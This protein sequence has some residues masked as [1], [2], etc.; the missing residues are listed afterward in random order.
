MLNRILLFIPT[1]NCEKQIGRVLQKINSAVQ[2]HI[3]EIVLI[4]N[5]STDNTIEA[6][7]GAALELGLS[8]VLL[9]NHENYN[10]GGSI[11][12]AFLYAIENNYDYIIS[13]HG[14]DQADI[15]DFLPILESEHYQNFDLT[16]GARFHKN[17]KL[18]GYSLVRRIGNQV[19]NQ[20]CAVINR[21]KIDDL[22]AGLNC[23]KVNFLQ[24][25]FFLKFPNN[26]TF[27][28][29]LLLYALN[30]KA[31]IIYIPISW[32]QEDQISNAKVLKQTFIILRLFAKYF[33][34]RGK[35]FEN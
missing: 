10:L 11:K 8:L 20:I 24:D 28:V 18:E 23:F 31:K 15:R 16:I 3:T 4:D 22:I 9:Q 5:R 12:R 6:A 1:Y 17:S 27:D 13:V 30:K 25:Q 2:K 33:F 19:L 14:D 35:T 32:R 26:L 34:L 7:K 21:R 29:H